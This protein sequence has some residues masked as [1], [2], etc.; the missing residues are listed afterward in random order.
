VDTIVCPVGRGGL[1]AGVAVGARAVKPDMRIVGVQTAACPSLYQSIKDGVFYSNYPTDEDTICDAV[2][3]G[4][5]QVDYEMLPALV[6][7]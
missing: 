3:G 1:A 6:D 2:V 4:A 7:E 5:G